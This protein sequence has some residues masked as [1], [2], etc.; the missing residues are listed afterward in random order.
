MILI[1]GLLLGRISFLHS[2]YPQ[3]VI[4]V[5]YK[6][7]GEKKEKETQQII[8]NNNNKP[9]QPKLGEII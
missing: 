2:A 7:K 3:K 9:K 8:I 1:W 6:R 4:L 5:S